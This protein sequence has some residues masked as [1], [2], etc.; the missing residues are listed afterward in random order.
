M[1]CRAL[2]LL[3]C[4]QHHTVWL[5]APDNMHHN[6][7]FCPAAA[8]S[9]TP[10]RPKLY[11]DSQTWADTFISELNDTHIEADLRLRHTPPELE[12]LEVSVLPQGAVHAWHIRQ[13]NRQQTGQYS[14]GV[15]CSTDVYRLGS[16]AVLPAGSAKLRGAQRVG[17]AGCMKQ[18]LP[19]TAS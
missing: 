6:L 19:T 4:T 17:S 10:H 14:L 9:D 1:P 7:T 12:V 11:N 5:H 13:C 2:C 15:L 18:G 8:C 3:S 16:T